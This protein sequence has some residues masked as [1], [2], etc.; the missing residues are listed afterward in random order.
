LKRRA[1]YDLVLL[2]R[3][4]ESNIAMDRQLREMYPNLL[5]LKIDIVFSEFPS[6]MTDAV[7]EHVLAALKRDALLDFDSLPGGLF[8]VI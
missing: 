8:D 5:T 3:D 4:S 7:P 6:R 2:G 1:D